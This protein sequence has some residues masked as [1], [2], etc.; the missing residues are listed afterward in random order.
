MGLPSR[1]RRRRHVHRPHLRDA[2]GRGRA[3]QDADHARRPVD[4]RDERPRPA[5]RALRPRRSPTFC[6]ELDILVHGTTTAD[7]TMIEM[8]GAP[9][10]LLVTE[11]HRDEIELRRCHKEEIWDPN[12]PGPTPIARRRARIPIPRAHELRGRGPAAARRGRGAPRR[13]TAEEARRALDRGDVPLLV[14]EPRARAPH[15]RDHPRGVPRRRAH[16]ALARGH[17]ARPR[18]RAGLDHARERVRRAAH[19]AL[20]GEPAGQA[21][22]APATTARC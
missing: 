3:R 14:R 10:G 4:R 8:N 6:R 5:R 13:A 11:G 12:Y 20:H 17:A 7:N 16:L 1:S 21:A 9:T 15:A 2:D 19:R 18:V 22:R